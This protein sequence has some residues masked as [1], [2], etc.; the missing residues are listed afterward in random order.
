[1]DPQLE[2]ICAVHGVFLRRE[3]MALGYH[4]RA[5]A[6][7]VKDG[8]WHR[9]R[10]GAYVSGQ[11]WRRADH[12]EKY[13]LFVLAT[14]RQSNTDVVPSHVSAVALHGGPLW[15]LSLNSSHLTRLDGRTGRSESGVEQHR[16]VFRPGDVIEV[17]GHRVMSPTR[18]ALEVSSIS[19]V[20]ASLC[21]FDDFLHRGL[22][23]QNMLAAR[24][25]T[26]NAWPGT[27]HTDIVLRLADGRRESAGESRTFYV[28]WRGHL[29][30]PQPQVEVYDENGIFIGRVDFAWPE[31]G[32]FLEFDGLRKYLKDRREG[33][34]IDDVI[35]REK[36]REEQIC[37][38]TGWRCIRV[39]WDDLRYPEHL[40]GRIRRM[41][42]GEILPG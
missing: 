5:I 28:C 38:V 22:T 33:E 8:T 15:G 2:A 36:R 32:V 23:T 1:M 11:T 9:V 12:D 27:L 42:T 37:E 18:A 20:E 30:W 25:Q 19:S 6:R 4:D 26:M 29:P 34:S 35:L 39:V 14:V 17:D 21:V 41:L 7:L 16:G 24:Y 3:A 13:R 31:H 10:R 40:A